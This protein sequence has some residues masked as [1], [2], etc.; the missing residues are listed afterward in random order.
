MTLKMYV[1]S[2]RAFLEASC[3]MRAVMESIPGAFLPFAGVEF[4][5]G[6]FSFSGGKDFNN[7]TIRVSLGLVRYPLSCHNNLEYAF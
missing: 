4:V 2:T 1:N 5:N 7:R 3:S 6:D